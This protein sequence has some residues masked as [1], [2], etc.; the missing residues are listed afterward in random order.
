MGIFSIGSSPT[1]KIQ[2]LRRTTEAERATKFSRRTAD[3]PEPRWEG[4]PLVRG[5]VEHRVT[6]WAVLGVGEKRHFWGG[7]W[8][9]YMI[10]M[11]V[12]LK[13]GDSRTMTIWILGRN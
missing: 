3:E 12:C 13:M 1:P 2:A 8:F 10:Y 6:Y 7:S 4:L 11:E 9:F 5:T